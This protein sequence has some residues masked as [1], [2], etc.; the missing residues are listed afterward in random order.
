MAK[1][2][3]PG[4]I[5]P[6]TPSAPAP[7]ATAPAG[8][9]GAAKPK[10][11]AGGTPRNPPPPPPP[12]PKR[13]EDIFANTQITLEPDEAETADFTPQE[14]SQM[15]MGIDPRQT[16]AAS[17]AP[18]PAPSAA[19]PK[20][21]TPAEALAAVRLV[22]QQAKQFSRGPAEMEKEMLQPYIERLQNRRANLRSGSTGYV[23]GLG[24]G[25]G[26]NV[27]VYPDYS[28]VQAP[29]RDEL[30][31]PVVGARAARQ[32]AD[33]YRQAVGEY[34]RQRVSTEAA[35]ADPYIDRRDLRSYAANTRG[36]L[37]RV[38]DLKASLREY[39]WADEDL[40][41]LE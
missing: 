32:L 8:G 20:P 38:A 24:K 11:A 1:F 29:T 13:D 33:E 39:G 36:A 6:A 30:A 34:E 5:E 10:A 31:V 18:A 21:A 37:Q 4:T 40:K 19:P 14:Y 26:R 9:G 12:P 7:K 28:K 35:K 2:K 41:T 15:A 16:R 25:D 17:K 27:V 23:K 22:A 3:K